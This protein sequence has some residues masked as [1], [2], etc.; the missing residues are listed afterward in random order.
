[1]QAGC[2]VIYAADIQALALVKTGKVNL[3]KGLSPVYDQDTV[4]AL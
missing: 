1:M 4:Q 3:R 2:T